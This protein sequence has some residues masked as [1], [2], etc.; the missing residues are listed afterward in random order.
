MCLCWPGTAQCY[1]FCFSSQRTS[2]FTRAM[3]TSSSPQDHPFPHP[4]SYEAKQK[5]KAACLPNSSRGD[6]IRIDYSFCCLIISKFP[7][8]CKSRRETLSQQSHLQKHHPLNTKGAKFLT[9][10]FICVVQGI[11][12]REGHC[13]ALWSNE[14]LPL[15]GFSFCSG[16]LGFQVFSSGRENWAGV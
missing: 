6:S 5:V 9:L 3:T 8:Y 13:R 14:S 11:C 7:N 12:R 4:C 1:S 15:M 16:V 10:Y 2:A